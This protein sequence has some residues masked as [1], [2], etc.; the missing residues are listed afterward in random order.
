MSRPLRR[1]SSS[2]P[3]A[4]TRGLALVLGATAASSVGSAR[5][6]APAE[7]PTAAPTRLPDG[8]E[9]EIDA[10]FEEPFWSTA[11]EIGALTQVSPIEGARP[12]KPTRVRMAYDADFL[13]LA[14][15]CFE[16]RD[17]VFARQMARDANI[18]FDDVVELWFDTFANQRFAYWFQIS[19]AGSR[20]DALL[21]DN[22]T[23]FIKDWDGIWYGRARITDRGWQAELAFP[24][25][26]L[27]FREGQ[28]TWGFNLLRRRKFN[29]ENSRWA[30]ARIAF[31]FFNLS[32]GGRL[33]GL[34]G[35]HQ[36]VG[37]DVTPYVTGTLTR[38]RFRGNDD[39]LGLGEQG[40]DLRYR[41]TPALNLR[42]TYN[43]DFAQTEVDN[44]QINL[45]RFPLFF[46]EK[47]DFFLEDTDV[48]DFGAPDRRQQML[49]FFSRRVG[50]DATGDE[51]PILLGGKLT[52]RVGDWN[53]G[54][55]GAFLE[56]QTEVTPATGDLGALD[57]PNA[58]EDYDAGLGVVRLSRNL[59]GESAVGMI[60][61]TGRPNAAGGSNTVVGADFRVGSSRLFGQGGQGSLWGYLV[62]SET[63]GTD[64]D[65]FAYG[66]EA[67]ST[68]T[69]WRHEVAFH[70]V[71]DDFNPELGFV[72]RGGTR[73]YRTYSQYTWRNQDGGWLRRANFELG[74]S[75]F[76]D[77]SGELQTL[78]V[79]LTWLGISL[80]TEDR[81]EVSTT[82]EHD[83]PDASFDVGP[84]TTVPA[85]EYDMV[86]HQI[87][88]EAND[89]RLIGGGV[90]VEYG[91]FFDGDLLRFQ[92]NPVFI[93]NEHIRIDVDYSEFHVDVPGGDFV[94]RL[95]SVGP[96]INFTPDIT[97][98]SLV[99]WD[100]DSD[101][102]GAQSRLRWIF[103]PGNELFLV[104]LFGWDDTTSSGALVPTTQELT[105]K[106]AWT[107][108][109]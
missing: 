2:P 48:F 26:T 78:R 20:G 82:Y 58:V 72:R 84:G 65:G 23:R 49:P 86:R 33:V 41:L 77:L 67:R 100:D 29:D 30:S 34:E 18:Q 99:Q 37:L 13:Y 71:E 61:T 10:R 57:D 43:T 59:G 88:L 22:G 101:S 94:T 62:G 4:W 46:P 15:E 8:V 25:K 91:D 1:E 73:Q 16:D 9:V 98:A 12:T 27:S 14:L 40:L 81:L 52:G 66:L 69:N 80:D 109:F 3:A 55:L 64:G 103:E 107:W 31:S 54:A 60:A 92:V 44:R 79:P 50:R 21:S 95:A 96:E 70:T 42:L 45:T 90:E 19:A 51:V 24:F 38:D 68:T 87:S 75:I 63:S 5:A 104:G 74:P 39:W 93:P 76:T 56:E 108:R 83:R 97:W 47:R 17:K 28:S 11:A 35:M 89:R 36:G 85:G 7:R 6:Q 102:I 53:I 32:V 105:L 106:V